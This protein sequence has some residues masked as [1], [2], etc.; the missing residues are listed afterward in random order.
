M[1]INSI[2][3]GATVDNLI[4][5]SDMCYEEKR[6]SVWLSMVAEHFLDKKI[7]KEVRCMKFIYIS[8][9]STYMKLQRRQK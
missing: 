4:L 7:R 2:L 8:Y 6:T 5:Y 3:K 9:D 1:S